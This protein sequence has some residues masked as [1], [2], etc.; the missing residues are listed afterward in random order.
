MNIC[1]LIYNISR[2]GGSERVTSLIANALSE[3]G[4]DV[5]ILN[6]CGN[7]KCFY[8]ISDKIKIHTLFNCENINHKKKYLSIV[9]KIYQ[10]YK[11]NK[12]DI[13]IEVFASL[14]LFVLPIKKILK[15]KNISWEHFN[16]TSNEGMN[17]IARI[18]ACRFSNA[19]ITLTNEDK[20]EYKKNIKNIKCKIDYIYNPTPFSNAT[21]SNLT[22]KNV[23]TVGRLTYQKGYDLLL[24]AWKYVE[25]KNKQW[26]LYIYGEGEDEEKLKE[27]QKQ[28]NL[29]NVVFCGKTKQIHKC[30][31]DASIYVSSSR[32]EGLPMCMI[33]AQSFGLPIV[34]F[35]CKTGPSEIV[36]NNVNG[37]LVENE[38][39][40][41]LAEK[42][43]KLMNDKNLLLNFASE[44]K[45][46]SKF[47]IDSIIEKWDLI[48]NS[49]K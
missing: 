37:F 34:S 1:F 31:Q 39:T 21:K 45:E 40:V 30:Y 24:Q 29:K 47:Q 15:I 17:K 3:K 8:N 42:L 36:N 33:E 43:L 38:N 13:S 46:S 14:S 26:K 22:K 16:F 20:E 2:A 10:F 32:F 49:L 11:K 25:E 44:V 5:T 12:I 4:Y 28:L 41:E 27:Q 19:L 6:I 7:N 23:I 9:K 35:N 18:F 48:I